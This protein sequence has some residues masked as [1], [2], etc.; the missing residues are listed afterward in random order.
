[1]RDINNPAVSDMANAEFGSCC[2]HPLRWSFVD[3]PQCDTD[4]Q[5]AAG[6]R[7]AGSP[8]R[9][10]DDVT[11]SVGQFTALTYQLSDGCTSV[12]LETRIVDSPITHVT[13]QGGHNY[14]LS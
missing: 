11:R 12:Q 14:W 13:D 6:N 5:D 4:Y 8:P 2:R 3:L 7:H 10:I 1:V 9:T